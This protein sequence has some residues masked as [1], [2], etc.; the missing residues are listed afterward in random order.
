M[1]NGRMAIPVATGEADVDTNRVGVVVPRTTTARKP[2]AAQF[3][4]VAGADLGRTFRWTG[5]TLVFGR[6]DANA[7]LTA[8]DVSLRHARVMLD[9]DQLVVEDLGSTNHTYV[10]G[11]RT[12]GRV[13]LRVGDRIQIGSTILLFTP[14]DELEERMRQIQRS[15]AI[16]ALAAGIAHDFRNALAVILMN[17]DVLDNP[18]LDLRRR[19]ALEDMRTAAASASQLV[20]RLLGLG[21]TELET[22]DPVALRDVVLRAAAILR[23]PHAPAIDVT[24]EIA[25]DVVVRG[26]FDELYQV[27]QNLFTNARDAMPDGGSISIRTQFLEL[28]AAE[29]LARQ[30][31]GAGPFIEVAVRDTGIGMDAATLARAFEPFFSTKPPARGSGL[32]LAMIERVVRRHGGSVTAESQPGHGTTLWLLLPVLRQAQRP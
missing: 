8:S 15:E 27:M 18:A 2:L 11:T 28:S 17:V 30:L 24:I 22:F 20:K 23:Q 12:A 16:G 9:E 31:P 29:A 7:I 6:G 1:H 5:L 10:N 3:V 25:A 4:C 13:P 21:R 32:G 14:H 19:E 26:S